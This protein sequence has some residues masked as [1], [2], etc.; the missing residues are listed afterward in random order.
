M[1]DDEVPEGPWTYEGIEVTMF[2]IT[3]GLKGTNVEGQGVLYFP[4]PKDWGPS[5]KLSIINQVATALMYTGTGTN[6]VKIRVRHD[7]SSHGNS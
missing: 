2:D 3:V 5:R 6:H 1:N 7:G 4:V